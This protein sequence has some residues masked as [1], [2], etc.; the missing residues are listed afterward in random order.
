MTRFYQLLQKS[1]RATF[2]HKKWRGLKF[3][4][5]GLSAV[6][7]CVTGLRLFVSKTN[8]LKVYNQW[9]ENFKTEFRSLKWLCPHDHNFISKCSQTSPQNSYFFTFFRW[10]GA[11]H[12]MFRCVSVRGT[13]Q[14]CVSLLLA[15]APCCRT[16]RRKRKRTVDDGKGEE[17]SFFPSFPAPL[18]FVAYCYFHWD[19]QQSLCGEEKFLCRCHS[20]YT[21]QLF[22]ARKLIIIDKCTRS[23]RFQS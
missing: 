8:K 7:D 14:F 9:F 3:P 4:Q 17:K 15:E 5:S 2:C 12:T 6:P 23:L 16:E 11:S 19:T 18:F 10:A 13:F 20:H 22:L 1:P 21:R